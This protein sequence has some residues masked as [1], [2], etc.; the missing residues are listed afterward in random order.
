MTLRIL[1]GV[2]EIAGDYD[3]FLL[4]LWGVLHDGSKPFPG[5]IDALTRFK[6]AGKR[7]VILSNAP[8]RA[9]MVAERLIEI[10]IPGTLYDALHSSGEEAW[11]HLRHRDDPFFRALGR[12]CY[13][14]GPRRDDPLLWG[15]DYDRVDDVAQ[16]DFLLAVGPENWE[17]DLTDFE[18]ALDAGLAR[19]L[20][21]V[22]A[23]AD[24]VVM[25]QGRRSICAGAMAQYYEQ[26]GGPV[27]WHGK[28]YRSV[29]EFCFS[30]FA[31]FGV[32][33]HR[34]IVAFG[35]SLRTDIAGA[36]G[37][38][39]DSVRVASGIHADEIGLTPETPLDP[40]RIAD[41]TAAHGA[42]PT[43]AMHEFCW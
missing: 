31:E 20:P 15:L 13:F 16:A 25:H 5:V 18:A 35:D 32:P 29:Y 33:D 37:V 11:R 34:R 30:L 19:K 4:D 27:R 1:R 10:G 12:R 3:A 8:R 21:M 26:R 7:L 43:A 28:P 14:L 38:G 2:R 24:L 22:C 23:N 17:E 42:V 36:A 39:I 9:A 41:L 6:T 40:K